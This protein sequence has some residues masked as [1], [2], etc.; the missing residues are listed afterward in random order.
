MINQRSDRALHHAG[1]GLSWRGMTWDGL[2]IDLRGLGVLREQRWILRDVNW[3]VP[4]GRCV[5]I[6]GPN[7]SGKST[8]ARVISGNLFPSTGECR[9]LGRAFGDSDLN[10][11]RQDVRL[12]QPAG[13]ADVD[14]ELSAIE[15]VL[16]GLFGTRALYHAVSAPMRLQAEAALEQVGLGGVATHRYETLS[17]GERVRALIARALVRRPGLLL[18]D[19]PTA[20]MDLLGREQVLATIERLFATTSQPSIT[21]ILITHHIEELPPATSDVIVLS[22]GQ[23]AACGPPEQVLEERTLSRVYGCP[24]QVRRGNGRF[25]LEVHPDAWK[26]LL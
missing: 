24:V 12:I 14:S 6:L 26:G 25:Y 17:S 5:A 18:M 15:V 23:V 19:E 20:G 9:I 4:A 1:A 2:A 13:P 22:Q 21:V 10:E 8:L 11:L 16:T 7:G 3:R